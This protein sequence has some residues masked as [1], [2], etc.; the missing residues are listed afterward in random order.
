M[1]PAA[2]LLQIHANLQK[3]SQQVVVNQHIYL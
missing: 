2:A 3:P 1:A